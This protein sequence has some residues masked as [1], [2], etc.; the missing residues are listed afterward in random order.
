MRKKSNLRYGDETTQ[1][2]NNERKI[3]QFHKRIETVR[4]L[5]DDIQQMKA[6]NTMGCTTLNGKN[7]MVDMPGFLGHAFYHLGESRKKRKKR[8]FLNPL[9]CSGERDYQSE[10]MKIAEDRDEWCRIRDIFIFI[11]FYFILEED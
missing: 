5:S 4:G 11:D 6:E 1:I 3:F 2:A 10:S 8:Q 9:Y 7:I